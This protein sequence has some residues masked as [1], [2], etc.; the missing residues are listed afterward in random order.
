MDIHKFNVFLD[1]AKTGNYSETAQRL[2]TT[3]GNI[4]KQI[5]SLEK[6]LKTKLFIRGHRQITLTESGRITEMYAKKIL[7]EFNS[8]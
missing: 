2:Y 7:H 5:L 3:Q 4:S 1:L 6:E 8:L